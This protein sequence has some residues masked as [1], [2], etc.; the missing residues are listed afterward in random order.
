MAING[1]IRTLLNFLIFVFRIYIVYFVLLMRMGVG[2][3]YH[4]L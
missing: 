2:R 3:K 1:K 4:N